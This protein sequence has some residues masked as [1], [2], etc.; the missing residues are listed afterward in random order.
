MENRLKEVIISVTNRCNLRCAMC[1]IPEA[2]NYGEMA[3]NE[4]EAIISDAV[5]LNPN[6]IVFSGG[7]PLL[8]HDI[9]ELIGFANK[10]MV[11]TCL[12]SNGT[13]IDD[14]VA[15][16]LASS[17]VG[18]VNISIEGDE[19]VHN[20]LRGKG[21]FKKAVYALESLSRNKV[22]TTIA[23]VVCKQNYR[24][25]APVVELA[26]KFGVTT[27]KFQPFNEI[28]LIEKNRKHGFFPPQSS[29][30]EIEQN[31]EEVIRLAD[32]YGIAVNPV[33]YLRNIP[34]Y[35]CGVWH[36]EPS[37]NCSAIWRSCPVSPDGSVYLCWVL[38][39]KIIGNARESGLLGVW[40]S[41][42]HNRMRGLIKREG[43]PG[44]FMSCY[45]YN[46][47]K[48]SFLPA[49]LLKARKLK[50]PKFYFYR[51]YQYLRYITAK[52]LNRLFSAAMS[53]KAKSPQASDVLREIRLARY[54]LKK[55]IRK[56]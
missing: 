44:C 6:S 27:I 48:Q 8:R 15:A 47:D 50:R 52:I 46:F 9:F 12:T 43:C 55:E 5:K 11:N 51:I 14:S 41:S 40:N 37:H 53:F 31:I 3:K 24:S 29:L 18:V 1:Q 4:L 26:H 22:E 28:F 2:G 33:D 42:R 10:Q 21:A 25:L 7:E 23:A 45:D 49:A 56:L 20:S 36:P 38:S 17:G 39:D 16:R 54:L 19:D 32:K 34:R 13:L 30:S 35:L